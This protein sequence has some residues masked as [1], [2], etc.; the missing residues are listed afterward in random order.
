MPQETVRTRE[1]ELELGSD[2]VVT[3]V[4]QTGDACLKGVLGLTD[5]ARLE[6]HARAIQAGRRAVDVALEP[7]GLRHV[8]ERPRDVAEEVGG[9]PL[10][11][12]GHELLLDA[13]EDLGQAG[14]LC[15]GLHRL[16]RP[17]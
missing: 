15:E 12:P 9:I 5:E 16:L 8:R 11:V 2:L 13:T 14:G 4:R 10:V 3:L 17:G 6:Q 7:L 1:L